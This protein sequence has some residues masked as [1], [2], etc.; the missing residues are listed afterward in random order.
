MQQEVSKINLLRNETDTDC[1]NRLKQICQDIV[2]V[3][4]VDKNWNFFQWDDT[5]K[6]KWTFMNND[7]AVE[8]VFHKLQQRGG[9]SGIAGAK[10]QDK[11]DQEGG[12]GSDDSDN[13]NDKDDDDYKMDDDDD[14]DNNDDQ[15][16]SSLDGTHQSNYASTF[17]TNEY[18][19]AEMS[20]LSPLMKNRDANQDEGR[21]VVKHAL[22]TYTKQQI[23]LHQ[24]CFDSGNTDCSDIRLIE[25][26]QFD[27][28]CNK[29]KSVWFSTDCYTSNQDGET[30]PTLL[31]DTDLVLMLSIFKRY[32]CLLGKKDISKLTEG[33]GEIVSNAVASPVVVYKQ[34]PDI[35]EVK[36]TEE[37]I[38]QHCNC[39]EEDKTVEMVDLNEYQVL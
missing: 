33:S 22:L 39:K 7:K 10:K 19:I 17:A 3:L 21:L 31:L 16:P 23:L 28:I 15:H 30:T 2:D 24:L 9:E 4:V 6:Y 35:Q 38:K 5:K 34:N 36:I 26:F 8:A 27:E 32:V 1:K 14:D 11:H 13:H 20:C 18:S 12:R 25:N 37:Q 29:L